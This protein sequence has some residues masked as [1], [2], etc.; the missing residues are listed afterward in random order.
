MSYPFNYLKMYRT[1]S[2]LSQ[3]DVVKLI[4]PNCSSCISTYERGQ[5][6]PNIEILLLYHHLFNVSIEEFFERESDQVK[7]KLISRIIFLIDDLKKEELVSW[8]LRKIEYLED[9]LER[10]RD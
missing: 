4:S 8:N 10:L 9:T 1:K 7:C 5:R 6:R 2:F 3:K